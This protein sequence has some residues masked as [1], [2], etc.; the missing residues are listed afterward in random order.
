MD[1]T[2]L[3]CCIFLY[4]LIGVIISFW[5]ELDGNPFAHFIVAYGWPVLLVVMFAC[6]ILDLWYERKRRIDRLEQTSHNHGNI[7]T[8]FAA[9]KAADKFKAQEYFGT[10]K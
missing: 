10:D 6:L 1:L 3:I 5:F 2:F 7:Y 8:D 4:F 9:W